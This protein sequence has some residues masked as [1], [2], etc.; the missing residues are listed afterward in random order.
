VDGAVQEPDLGRDRS[1]AGSRAGRR[2][3]REGQEEE[4]PGEMVNGAHIPVPI[5]IKF[6]LVSFGAGWAEGSN[7]P[8]R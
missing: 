1:I 2:G 5:L 4:G 3:F 6:V 7:H 8:P